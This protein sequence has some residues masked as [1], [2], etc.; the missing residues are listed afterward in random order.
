MAFQSPDS[1]DDEKLGDSIYKSS[2]TAKA[3]AEAKQAAASLMTITPHNSTPLAN[4]VNGQIEPQTRPQQQVKRKITVNGSD[5]IVQ[6]KSN[7]RR[8]SAHKLESPMCSVEGCTNIARNGGVCRRHGATVRWCIHEGCPDQVSNSGVCMRHGATVER[9]SHEGCANNALRGGVCVRHGAVLKVKRCN[10]E[11]C[12]N[13]VA[14][15]GVCIRHGATVKR[16]SHEG[17]PNR[18]YKGGV[19]GRHQAKH[20]SKTSCKEYNHERNSNFKGG[21]SRMNGAQPKL[22]INEGCTNIALEGGVCARHGTKFTCKPCGNEGSEVEGESEAHKMRVVSTC[23]NFAQKGGVCTSHGA[24]NT[25]KICTHKGCV[26][27]AMQ[28]GGVCAMH[29]AFPFKLYAMLEYA[30]DSSHSPAVSWNPDGRSFVIRDVEAVT[31]RSFTSELNLWGFENL[32]SHT[33]TW[34]HEYFI[35]GNIDGLELMKRIEIKGGLSESSEQMMMLEQKVESALEQRK[36]DRQMKGIGEGPLPGRGGGG[37]SDSIGGRLGG[38][39]APDGRSISGGSKMPVKYPLDDAG[40]LDSRELMLNF[41]YLREQMIVNIM[42][43]GMMEGVSMGGGGGMG[44]QMMGSM[45]NTP[46]T[47]MQPTLGNAGGSSNSNYAANSLRKQKYSIDQLSMSGG[48]S[49]G[50]GGSTGPK[51]SFLQRE[52]ITDAGKMSRPCSHEGCTIFSQRCDVCISHGAKD[53]PKT[54]DIR[55]DVC[56]TPLTYKPSRTAK[57]IAEAKH[58]TSSMP[59]TLHGST[60]LANVSGKIELQTRP[61]QIK[62]NITMEGSDD[63][64]PKR[65]RWERASSLE[66]C[67]NNATLHGVCWTPLIYK[68]SH[69]AKATGEAKQA[70]PP[71]STTPRNSTH[72][73]NA[74]G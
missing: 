4:D 38:S 58:A 51:Q 70:V 66:G 50:A 34:F 43:F 68:P 60:H 41:K 56:W 1:D 14:N 69:T 23:T 67:T 21:V 37:P 12:H 25:N 19:C 16:C 17:C 45:L 39:S 30:A 5:L 71:L 7:Y 33:H 73:A 53:T 40:R 52:Q 6:G 64:A 49:D 42:G 74:D 9:C 24:T 62:R 20:G 57:G 55:R 44:T 13:Q 29:D 8:L 32:P 46:G 28:E 11:G 3:I 47:S 61:Q 10:H 2:R 36:L 54:R 15:S 26:N 35:R 72:L 48:G 22:C 31:F 18:G 63:T 65:V 59:A 27:Y